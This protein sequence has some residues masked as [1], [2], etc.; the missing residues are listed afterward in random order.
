MERSSAGWQLGRQ[1]PLPLSFGAVVDGDEDVAWLVTRSDDGVRDYAHRLTMERRGLRDGSATRAVIPGSVTSHSAHGGH[2]WVVAVPEL[3]QPPGTP[4][5]LLLRLSTDVNGEIMISGISG[6]PDITAL[7]PRP[8]PP[9]GLDP[10]SWAEARRADL[11]A[12]LTGGLINDETGHARPFLS[13]ITIDSVSLEGSFPD[14]ECLIRFRADPRPGVTYG[15]RIRCFDETGYPTWPQF[16][17]VY[18]QEDIDGG[19]LPPPSPENADSA[20]TIWI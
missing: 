5:R 3:P 6:W 8:Q 18:L 16:A 11:E 1:V 13:R 14:T 7:L 15:R 19:N 10:P 12:V 4:S 9:A 20:D 2:A 17:A